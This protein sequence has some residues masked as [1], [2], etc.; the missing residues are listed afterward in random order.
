MET[1]KLSTI[2]QEIEAK[3]TNVNYAA[4]PYLDA[5]HSLHGIND[6]FGYDDAKSIVIYFA[7]NAGG[8]RG[9]DARRIKAELKSLT[10][11]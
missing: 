6:K 5:M 4:R 3:W 7:A 9:D 8:W 10:T 2:A 1:R 11:A